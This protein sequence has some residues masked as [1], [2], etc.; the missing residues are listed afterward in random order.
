MKRWI[1]AL[2][3]VVLLA[4]S[5]FFV[6]SHFTERSRQTGNVRHDAQWFTISLKIGNERAVA[7][8]LARPKMEW[9]ILEQALHTHAQS[10][11]KTD[12]ETVPVN[13][14]AD[15]PILFATFHCTGGAA[16]TFYTE[17]G[18]DVWRIAELKAE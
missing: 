15:G 17:D 10:L 16:L 12:F 14:R 18:G 2:A 4:I 3:I 9:P 11:L 8:Y 1:I 5:A 13:F 7:N 6:A